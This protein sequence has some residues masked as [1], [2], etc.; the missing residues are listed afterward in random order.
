M[1]WQRAA[2]AANGS[3]DLRA[4]AASSPIRTSLARYCSTTQTV[5]ELAKGLLIAFAQMIPRDRIISDRW[6]LTVEEQNAFASW[7]G[8]LPT[9]S[10]SASYSATTIAR[11]RVRYCCGVHI[12]RG[13]RL[14]KFICRN[15]IFA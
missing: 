2:C 11:D 4:N 14:A 1:R 5:A 15:S 3:G 8:R 6:C 7:V 12:A 13:D 10:L 9:E